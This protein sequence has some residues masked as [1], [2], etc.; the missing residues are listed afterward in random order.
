[1]LCPACGHSIAEGAKFCSECGAAQS[2]RCPGCANELPLNAKFCPQCGAS[3]APH[4]P[5]REGRREPRTPLDEAERRQ[6]T[7]LFSDLAGS[8]ELSARLDPE[9]F[10]D[11]VAAYHGA[12]AAAIERAGGYVAKYLGDGVLALFGYPRA[13]E[14]DAARAIRGG[15]AI[16]AAVRALESRPSSHGAR[17]PVRIGIHTGEVVVGKGGGDDLDIFGETP[18]LAARV[19]SAADVDSILVTEATRRLAGNEFVFE[20]RGSQSFKG[21]RDAVALHRVERWSLASERLDSAPDVDGGAFVGRERERAALRDCWREAVAGRGRTVILRGEPGI[22]KSRFLQALHDDCGA[23]VRWLECHGSAHHQN[24]DLH[25]LRELLA[26]EAAASDRSAKALPDGLRATLADAVLES[27]L[28]VESGERAAGRTQNPERYRQQTLTTLADWAIGLARA[29]PTVLAMEDLHWMDS[30]TLDFIRLLAERGRDAALLLALTTRETAMQPQLGGLEAQIFDLEPLSEGD[31]RTIVRQCAGTAPLSQKAIE[32]ILQRGDGIPLFVEEL[33]RFFA[34]AGESAA[35]SAQAIPTSLKSLL[36][37]RIDRLGASKSVAQFG[38]VLGR[39]F[40]YPLLRAVSDLPDATLATALAELEDAGILVRS[41]TAET[42]HYAFR[43][44]LVCDAAYE[45]LLRSARKR[46]HADVAAALVQQFAD[47]ATRHPEVVAHHY[48]LAQDHA[49]AVRYWRRAARGGMARGAY[50]EAL[51][52]LRSALHAVTKLGDAAPAEDALSL[53]LLLGQA[54]SATHGQTHHETRGAFERA[55]E[56]C[57]QLADSAHLIRV[58]TGIYEVAVSQGAMD[59]AREVASQ[60]RDLGIRNRDATLLT[61]AHTAT[62]MTALAG[63]DFAAAREEF[64]QVVI[65]HE[66]R[67]RRRDFMTGFTARSYRPILTW[68]LGEPDKALRQ[69]DD[70]LEL[71]VAVD[72]PFALVL[73]LNGVGLIHAFRGDTR[74]LIET[75]TRLDSLARENGYVLFQHSAACLN[76]IGRLRGGDREGLA[77]LRAAIQ[78]ITDTGQASWSTIFLPFLAEGLGDAN[79]WRE[80]LSLVERAL[81]DDEERGHGLCTAEFL[82]LRAHAMALRGDSRDAVVAAFSTAIDTAR[83]TG[84]RAFALRS[85]TSLSRFLRQRGE[86][87]GS[88]DT[89][90]EALAGWTEG[91]DT[92]DLQRAR[93]LRDELDAAPMRLHQG[94]GDR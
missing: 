45:L 46:L 17:L 41:G 50:V 35:A 62:G 73:V 53:N 63:G 3:L 71:A 34:A 93:A 11:V 78:G 20:S 85:A 52:H 28:G 40:P 57:V 22:G 38:A 7:V 69:C 81:A 58:L 8:T 51:V 2:A 48:A 31:A 61:S 5:V 76:A 10:R 59:T 24:T 79:E 37:H 74:A 55:R 25:P 67:L 29:H 77:A 14:D 94:G 90:V 44:A 89:L 84:A 70:E 54:L 47:E 82:R 75:A 36:M 91:G 72:N 19:Q 33:T 83:A 32:Q 68:I 23:E 60:M 65:H 43:H 64:E 30:S 16:L 18:N 13:H 1:M 6:L 92:V 27:L 87:D 15:L 66:P 49:A 42:R 86:Y 21:I 88:R 4:A 26:A 12:A 39:T 9:D 80:L 56:L